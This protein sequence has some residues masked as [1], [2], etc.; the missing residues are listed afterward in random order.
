MFYFL[1][2]KFTERN[3]ERKGVHWMVGFLAVEGDTSG[4]Q[5]VGWVNCG[6]DGYP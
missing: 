5:V 3:Y 2:G 4:G 6:R 1:L